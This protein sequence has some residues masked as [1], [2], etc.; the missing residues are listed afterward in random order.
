M[1]KYTW[2]KYTRT[3]Y[4]GQNLPEQNIPGQNTGQYIQDKIYR[5]KC[6]GQNMLDKKILNKIYFVNCRP[7]IR[8]YAINC[9]LLLLRDRGWKERIVI[10]GTDSNSKSTRKRYLLY[11]KLVLKI[12]LTIDF[13][14]KHERDIRRSLYSFLHSIKLNE[15]KL[16]NFIIYKKFLQLRSG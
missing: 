14:A 10:S 7:T 13:I 2:T 5:T 6:A 3:K 11:F 8:S 9:N 1:T 15:L 16:N 4:T 12:H